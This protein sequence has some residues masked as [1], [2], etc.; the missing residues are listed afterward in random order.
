MTF[1]KFVLEVLGLAPHGTAARLCEDTSI[2]KTE[3][4]NWRHGRRSLPDAKLIEA[5][6]WLWKNGLVRVECAI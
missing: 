3:L 1:E 4:S 5:F 6:D 2:N